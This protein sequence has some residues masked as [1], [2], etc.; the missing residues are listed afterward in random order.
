MLAEALCLST[1]Q[2]TKEHFHES[3][4]GSSSNSFFSWFR[5]PKEAFSTDSSV[6][7]YKLSEDELVENANNL[8]ESFK[9]VKET[10][11]LVN[12]IQKNFGWTSSTQTKL[13]K[14]GGPEFSAWLNEY[15][16]VY[17][18]QIDPERLEG[19]KLEG[20]KQLSENKWEVVL[21]HSQMV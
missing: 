1:L 2:S 10:S 5:Q 11:K 14:I 16:P 8:V 21:S 13:E 7:I 17:R 4:F 20:W 12:S 19:L 18:L 3:S 15:V 6:I 9:S